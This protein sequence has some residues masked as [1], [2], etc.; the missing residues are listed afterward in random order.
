MSAAG[1]WAASPPASRTGSTPR[2]FDAVVR[3]PG[4]PARRARPRPVCSDLE[5][6]QRLMASPVLMAL[7]DIPW[8]PFF[9]F[10]IASFTP[11]SACSR[12]SGGAVLI[13]DH[14]AQPVGDPQ[15]DAQVER[16]D[17]PGRA[18]LRPDARANREMVQ[19][20]RACAAH[21]FLRWQ[22]ARAKSLSG[23][24]GSADLTGSFSTADDRPCA[25]CCNRRCSASA[26]ISCC[27]TN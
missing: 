20:T 24:I 25:S 2:V 21:A 4:R 15:S 23:Q 5:S 12:L 7:F 14:G 9:L 10:G 11:G 26:P 19:A 3:R 27:R 22:K 6:V 16:R 18:D 13:V 1:S 8:T 17:L